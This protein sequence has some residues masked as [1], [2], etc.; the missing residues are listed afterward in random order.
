MMQP[1]IQ[2]KYHAEV[3][4]NLYKDFN[5]PN[6]MMVPKLSKIVVNT[7][8]S[9]AISNVKL[10]HAAAKELT[11]IT[12]QKTVITKARRSI[13]NFRLREGMPIGAKVTL[14]RKKMWEFFDRLTAIA[15]P[16]IRDFR[17]LEPK[18]FD[19]R[20][21]YTMGIVEQ[22]VF[23]EISYDKI[24]KMNGFNIT[25]V[26]TANTDAEALALLTRLGMPFASA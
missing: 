18:G 9:D 20:G 12:G 15:I 6:K 4:E 11:L 24:Q 13:A 23:P 22:I 14:R 21:N 26:T 16:R 8:M 1:R 10:L 25:F 5:Y 19:G 7:S 2:K 17:G 3:F